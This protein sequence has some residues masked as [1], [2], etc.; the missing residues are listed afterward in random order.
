[1][2]LK[3]DIYMENNEFVKVRPSWKKVKVKKTAKVIK[4]IPQVSFSSVLKPNHVSI[5]RIGFNK[6]ATKLLGVSKSTKCDL[7]IHKK[8]KKVAITIL[9]ECSTEDSF[10]FSYSKG[11]SCIRRK[12][13]FSILEIPSEVIRTLQINKKP[14]IS[15]IENK[16]SLF[17][18]KLPE[19][20]DFSKEDTPYSIGI[21]PE[22]MSSGNKRKRTT[23]MPH[24]VELEK[25]LENL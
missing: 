22:V 25:E 16:N 3:K 23:D 5:D 13:L 20:S 19:K 6:A 24:D 8:E 1:M 14:F 21:D 7:L 4:E 2:Y 11:N 18:F 9:Y 10:T 17:I 12:D 15:D